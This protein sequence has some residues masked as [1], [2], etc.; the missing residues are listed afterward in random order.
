MAP[1]VPH[2]IGPLET[3]PGHAAYLYDDRRSFVAAAARFLTAG[4]ARNERLVYVGSGG[5]DDLLAELGGLPGAPELVKRGALDVVDAGALYGDDV[6]PLDRVRTYEAHT[7]D[8]VETGYSGLCVA[9]DVSSLVRT[10][11]S[12]RA[13]AR[14]EHLIDRSVAD[15]LP[16]RALCGYDRSGLPAYGTDLPGCLHA[17]SHGAH[18]DV[19][20]RAAGRGRIAVDGEVDSMADTW[21]AALDV[22]LDDGQANVIDGARWTFTDHRAL[23][24]LDDVAMSKG[25]TVRVVNASSAVRRV[26]ELVELVAVRVEGTRP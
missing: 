13:F 6:D 8:A 1:H 20:V 14:Y 23:L 2:G 19:R 10:T 21:A 16:F 18:C 3:F 24:R 12:M 5:R 22:A 11:E 9:A 4:R 25:A 7:A 15:G 26:A 17:R